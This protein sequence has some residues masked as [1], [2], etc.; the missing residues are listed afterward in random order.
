MNSKQ[1]TIVHIAGHY[2]P[3]TGGLERVIKMSAEGLAA[4]GYNVRVLTSDID[5]EGSNVEERKNP[6][7]TAMWSFEF[8]HIPFAPMFPLRLLMLP[9]NSLIH[10]HLSQAYYPELVLLISKSRGIPYVAHF[11]LDVMPS[12]FFGSIFVI[13]KKLLWGPILRG[14]ERV[15]TC[16]VDQAVVVE[17]KFGVQKEKVRVIPNAVSD[18]FFFDN[19]NTTLGKEFRLLYIGRLSLQKRIERIINAV[20]KLTIPARLT[21]VGDGEDRQKLDSLVSELGLTN[22]SFEGKKNDIEMQSYHRDNDLFLMCSDNEGGTP[23]VSLEA[24]AGGMPVMGTKVS[25]IKE[26]LNGVG[27]LIEEPFAENFA[28]AIEE[29][30][31]TP[32]ELSRYSALSTAKA[33]QYS[34]SRFMD[35]LEAVYK[36]I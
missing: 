30:W 27:I 34:W 33:K 23:L 19:H 5:L 24:M 10:L 20:S 6:K 14:A 21:I 29:L 28:K 22:V 9:K 35:Q 3:H 31:R 17:Q 1:K 18:D 8:A 4:R 12:G 15:I 26:F 7:V 2:P 11:H 16:S 13:Y 36:E 32:E 25:G